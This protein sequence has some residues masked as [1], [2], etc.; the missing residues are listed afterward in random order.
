[1]EKGINDYVEW[2]MGIA[3]DCCEGRG[4]ERRRGDKRA[5]KLRHGDIQE[6]A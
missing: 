6:V 5:E 4:S 2:C 3:G 1:M